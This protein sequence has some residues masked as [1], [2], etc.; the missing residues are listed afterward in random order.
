MGF[1]LVPADH[2]LFV[3]KEGDQFIALLVYVDDIVMMMVNSLQQIQNIKSCLHDKFKMKDLGEMKFFLG[4]EIARSKS[5]I[6]VCQKKFK[7]DL[8][9]DSRFLESKLAVTSMK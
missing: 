7:L 6:H 8:L 4:L 1:H 5:G 2:S 9:A 3:K